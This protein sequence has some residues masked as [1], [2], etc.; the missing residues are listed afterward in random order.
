MC[1]RALVFGAIAA[2]M[3]LMSL[4]SAQAYDVGQSNC[5]LSQQISQAFKT[6]APNIGMGSNGNQSGPTNCYEI[7][8]NVQTFRAMKRGH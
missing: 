1:A 6:S 3:T 7:G 5:L 4:S 8:T 2:S